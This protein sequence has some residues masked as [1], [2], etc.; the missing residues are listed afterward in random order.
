MDKNLLKIYFWILVFLIV[1]INLFPNLFFNINNVYAHLKSKINNFIMKDE[2][3]NLNIN[4]NGANI[5]VMFDDGWDSQYEIA[6]KYMKEKNMVGS[7]SIIPSYVGKYDYMNKAQINDVYN[8]NWDTLNHTYNHYNL[9][10]ISIKKQISEIKKAEK[11][12]DRNNFKNNIKTLI[13]PEGDFDDNNLYKIKQM[14]YDTTRG[15]IEGYNDF[16]ADD[17]YN[18]KVKNINSNIPLSE[19]INSIDY[20]IENNK[21]IILLFHKLEEKYDVS[22]MVYKI[23][24]FYKIIDYIDSV[25]GRVNILTYTDWIRISIFNKAKW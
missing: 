4:M 11:W 18:L 22:L 1:S 3:I 25:R 23:K 16:F 2:V 14:G 21:T 20:A 5:I 15:V 6:Y 7:I 24:D 17:L 19:V 9:K 10:K 12:S 13:Y 8:N